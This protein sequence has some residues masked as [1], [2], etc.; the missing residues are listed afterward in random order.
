[1]SNN[2]IRKR[3]KITII[4]GGAAGMTAAIS[5][6]RV[7]GGNQVRII[8]KNDK[9][10]RKIL[11]T[12]NGRCNYTN[13]LCTNHDLKSNE[14]LTTND[15]NFSRGI[16][17]Q[18][19]INDTINFFEELG[20]LP[21]EEGEGRV[22]P[23]SE[24]AS[25]VQEALKSELEHLGVEIIYHKNVKSVTLILEEEKNRNNTPLGFE[26][27]L[28]SGEKLESKKIII[29]TGGKAGAQYGSTGDGYQ[30]AK[31]FGHTIIKPIPA[32]VQLTSDNNVFNQL[33]GVRAK[34]NVVLIKN[35]EQVSEM[36]SGEI[37]F[38]EEGI[39]G[40]CIFNLS[41]QI[42]LDE[43]AEEGFHN[44][45]IKID[46]IP[47]FEGSKLLEKL[48]CRVESMKYKRKEEFLNGILNKKLAA[49]ILKVAGIKTSGQTED[50]IMDLNKLVKILK[51]WEIQISGTKG[52][53]D[54][55]VT[56]G[57]IKTT[58]INDETLESRLTR[59]LYFAGEVIDVDG[60]CGGYNLQWAW[61]SGFIAGKAASKSY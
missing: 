29:A 13:I 51:G 43:N 59:D 38:T 57:G 4:G 19:G 48:F 34:G 27:T 37:Q 24:Q 49:V 30:I 56:S 3:V 39:S 28:E 58:E 10:G 50:I 47:D 60:K 40:I 53:K 14:A 26:I 31:S 17:L 23:Y 18:F 46:L 8:E 22:Y 25:S 52:W 54:A 21:R 5:A 12:G 15:E 33:K 44:Y 41:R 7:V 2:S 20:I 6:A 55:Q 45:K 1:M 16:L 61:T 9:L 36:E 35:N 32:L 11:A 42:R